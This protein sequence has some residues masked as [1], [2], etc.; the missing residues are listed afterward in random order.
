MSN[1]NNRLSA[2]KK[3]VSSLQESV[4]NFNVDDVMIKIY[5]L[6]VIVKD[7]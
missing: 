2:V 4:C 7:S 1:K 5:H 6:L 3:I